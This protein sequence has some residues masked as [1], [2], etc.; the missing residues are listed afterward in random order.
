MIL[1]R[2]S[3]PS[4]RPRPVAH[5]DLERLLRLDHPTPLVT[6]SRPRRRPDRVLVIARCVAAG[7]MATTF[8]ALEWAIQAVGR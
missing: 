8:V 6:R 4:I 2:E 5:D 3:H 1:S 7:S